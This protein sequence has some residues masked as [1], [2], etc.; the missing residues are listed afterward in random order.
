MTDDAKTERKRLNT[1]Q[2]ASYGAPSM[3]LS[4]VALPLAV[5]LTPV[6]ADSAGF[7][8]SLA[9]V[10]LMLALSRVFDGVTDPVIGFM[11]D[12]IRTRWGRRK[13]FVLIGMP[14]FMLGFGY[15]GFRPSSFDR[16]PGSA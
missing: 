16:L 14:I 8:L 11:S 7:G 4:M 15:C 12:R 1:Y 5:Y 6:Y 9:F 13:P 2:L 10:G 3:P